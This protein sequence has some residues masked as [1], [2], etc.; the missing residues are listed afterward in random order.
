MYGYLFFSFGE[1]KQQDKGTSRPAR[2]I[3]LR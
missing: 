3:V 2:A 1:E